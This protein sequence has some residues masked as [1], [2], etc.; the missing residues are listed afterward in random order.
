[1]TPCSQ[2]GYISTCKWSQSHG[3]N[4]GR[5]L[6]VREG[7][8]GEDRPAYRSRTGHSGSRIACPL[9]RGRFRVRT[10]HPSRSNQRERSSRSTAGLGDIGLR[11]WRQRNSGLQG[12]SRTN[13]AHRSH[14]ERQIRMCVRLRCRYSGAAY[15]YLHIGHRT[16]GRS[17]VE[18]GR[19]ARHPPDLPLLSATPP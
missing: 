2:V 18:I 1:M 11:A 12:A 19:A 10:G 13:P 17:G 3:H 15:R 9:H 7:G 4:G 6:Y 16:A 5:C 8:D 14:T